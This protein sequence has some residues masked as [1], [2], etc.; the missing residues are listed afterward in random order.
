MEATPPAPPGPDPSVICTLSDG[1]LV[2]QRLPRMRAC[3]QRD[4]KGKICAG[5]LK[6]WFRSGPEVAERVGANAEIY[7]CERC[8]TLYLPHPD[9]PR[10]GTLSY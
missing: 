9:D 3:N 4:A 6:R 8:Q 10:T 1:T 2:K 5:H 7:R